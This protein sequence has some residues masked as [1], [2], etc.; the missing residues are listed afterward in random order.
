MAD[1]LE[2]GR[3]VFKLLGDIGADLAQPPATGAAAAGLASGVLVRSCGLGAQQLGLAWQVLRQAAGYGGGVGGIQ[4]IGRNR[5][6]G[7]RRFIQWFTLDQG[8]LPPVQLL[9]GAAELGAHALEQLQLELVDGEPEQGDLGPLR[10]YDTPQFSLG[11]RG[12]VG[13]GGRG[14]H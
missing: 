1:D 10:L 8:H 12:F 4:P 2:V 13:G 14:L 6:P 11:A 5:R 7:R 3:N 9:T